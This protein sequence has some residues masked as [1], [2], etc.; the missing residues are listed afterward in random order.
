MEY[1]R[2]INPMYYK[3]RSRTDKKTHIETHTINTFAFEISVKI[4]RNTTNR[5]REQEETRRR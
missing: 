5:S 4:P 3:G 2:Q 1:N